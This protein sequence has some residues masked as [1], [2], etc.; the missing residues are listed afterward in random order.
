MGITS[1]GDELARFGRGGLKL[2][3]GVTSEAESSLIL[4]VQ[5]T[6]KGSR[7]CPMNTTERDAIS[8]PAEGSL[9]Y[10]TSSNAYQYYNGSSWLGLDPSV[11]TNTLPTLVNSTIDVSPPLLTTSDDWLPDNVIPPGT[12]TSFS[13]SIDL[14]VTCTTAWVQLAYRYPLASGRLWDLQSGQRDIEPIQT[15]TDYQNSWVYVTEDFNRATR[16]TSHSTEQD[17]ITG[18]QLNFGSTLGA[19]Y[20]TLGYMFG[21][22][23]I[24]G[25]LASVFLTNS[26]PNDGTLFYVR[27]MYLDNSGATTLL[28]IDFENS[29]ACQGMTVAG[30]NVSASIAVYPS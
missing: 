28:V 24:G 17:P 18:T 9:I 25:N 21:S 27:S 3:H 16:F 13:K 22:Y 5:S 1:N 26:V 10:N 7:F 8:S 2:Q 12:T 30:S 6:A 29:P 23:S 14:G 19:S 15:N 20:A 4:D 11:P